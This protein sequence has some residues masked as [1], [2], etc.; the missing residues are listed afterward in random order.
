MTPWISQQQ[1]ILHRLVTHY[2]VSMADKPISYGEAL[3]LLAESQAFRHF[4]SRIIVESPFKALRWE[5]PAISVTTLVKPFEFV[6]VDSPFL[7]TSPDENVFSPYF[8]EEAEEVT[9]KAVL[10]LGRTATLIVPRKLD[11]AQK[12]AHLKSFLAEA[13]ETQLHALWILVAKTAQAQLNDKP[14]W[15]STAGGGVSWLHV[16]LERKPK[17]Y[18]FRQ[19]ALDI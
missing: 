5:T 8:T 16:R 6:L 15:I 7:V 19:Y 4:L 11:D 3:Q 18:T 14:L 13:P 12:Y 17:Y 1:P 9:C 10:N 2:Q